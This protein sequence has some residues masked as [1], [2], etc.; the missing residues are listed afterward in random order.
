V[1]RR[2]ERQETNAQYHF[3]AEDKELLNPAQGFLP[4]AR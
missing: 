1:T 3:F 4:A 2:N